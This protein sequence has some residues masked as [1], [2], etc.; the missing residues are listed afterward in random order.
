MAARTE[1]LIDMCSNN[2]FAGLSLDYLNDKGLERLRAGLYAEGYKIPDAANTQARLDIAGF[3]LWVIAPP[4]QPNGCNHVLFGIGR[5]GKL[6]EA[7]PSGG[8]SFIRDTKSDPSLI[9]GLKPDSD[10]TSNH[11]TQSFLPRRPGRN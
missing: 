10:I 6:P 2:G 3:H 5:A 4:I 9:P 11:I 1:R 7:I 8:M